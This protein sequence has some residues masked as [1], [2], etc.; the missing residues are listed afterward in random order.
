MHEIMPFT[1]SNLVRLEREILTRHNRINLKKDWQD[2]KEAGE[3]LIEARGEV[4]EGEWVKWVSV[5]LKIDRSTASRYVQ[6][7]R[8][9]D[10]IEARIGDGASSHRLSI[11]GVK[12][13]HGNFLVVG[14][15]LT[16]NGIT[17]FLRLGR[18]TN[19]TVTDLRFGRGH[20]RLRGE[21]ASEDSIAD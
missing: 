1:S 9:S 21:C 10:I 11:D 16:P 12:S 20:D 4:P 3:F 6:I 19:V 5:R 8:G 14:F 17:P 18:E 13:S 7:A 2:A 15:N